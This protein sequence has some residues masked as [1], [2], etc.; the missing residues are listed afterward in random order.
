MTVL[1]EYI[2]TPDP[3]RPGAY[4][5]EIVGHKRRVERRLKSLIDKRLGESVNIIIR[6]YITDN[7]SVF[8]LA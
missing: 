7:F 3:L 8:V 1:L 4:R 2:Y 5:L 6:N